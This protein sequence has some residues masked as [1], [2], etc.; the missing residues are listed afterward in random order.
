MI[1]F[2]PYLIAF[3]IGHP[4][5]K[6]SDGFEI[7]AVVQATLVALGL[8]LPAV[9]LLVSNRTLRIVAMVTLAAIVA[10]V[11]FYADV[12]WNSG[13][14][15]EWALQDVLDPLL[16]RPVAGPSLVR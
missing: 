8:S 3:I 2:W 1:A 16:V 14:V 7:V 15:R 11:L 5:A 12:R 4:A 9:L 10:N 13:L 6:G